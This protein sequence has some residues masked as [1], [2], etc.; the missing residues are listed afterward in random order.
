VDGVSRGFS[1]RGPETPRNHVGPFSTGGLYGPILSNP[2]ETT[3]THAARNPRP[4]T[5]GIA[6]PRT[7][8]A[9]GRDDAAATTEG[10]SPA[11]ATE[12]K[13]PAG[14]RRS[15]H[16][17]AR[18]CPTPALL[19]QRTGLLPGGK[20]SPPLPSPPPLPAS[21]LTLS[22]VVSHRRRRARQERVLF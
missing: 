17:A 8:P 19:L 21:V 7:P 3:R 18:L 20:P 14:E 12:G 16:A 13:S 4:A 2:R 9:R 15:P 1:S 22:P 10:K 5:Q 6:R 11:S